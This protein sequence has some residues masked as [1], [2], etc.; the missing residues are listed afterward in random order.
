MRI[1]VL[2]TGALG[3]FVLTLPVLERLSEI[4]SSLTLIAPVRYRALFGRADRWIDAESPLPRLDGELGLAWTASGGSLLRAAGL[5]EVLVGAPLPGPGV[6]Q[7]DNLWAPLEALGLGPRDRDPR[8]GSGA[9]GV[10]GPVVIAPGSGGQRKRWP[11]SRWRAVAEGLESGLWVGGPQEAGEAGWGTPRRDDLDL[12]G[13]IGLAQ[14]CRAWLGPD[15]GPSHLAA[16]AGARVG[17]VFTATDPACW[18]PLGAKVFDAEVAPEAVRG[19][20]R[21]DGLR[22]S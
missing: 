15:S 9:S 3:D 22:W 14:G 19:W 20:C 17:V 4:A 5:A 18:A 10:G 6:H 11:L 16:A 13:L 1:V 21:P 12:V 7:A 8:V 2:R